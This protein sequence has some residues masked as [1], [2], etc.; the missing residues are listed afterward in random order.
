MLFVAR[1]SPSPPI[2]VKAKIKTAHSI[3]R[4]VK[5]RNI[6]KVDEPKFAEIIPGAEDNLN[7]KPTATMIAAACELHIV[8]KGKFLRNP[9]FIV[10]LFI[11]KPL[12]VSIFVDASAVLRG[13]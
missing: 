13:D 12:I 8:P 3:S 2:F 4:A 1:K 6:Q 11:H 10:L 7:A 9:C 5:P